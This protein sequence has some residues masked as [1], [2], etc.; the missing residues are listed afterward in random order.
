M[1]RFFC[2]II[3][4]MIQPKTNFIEKCLAFCGNIFPVKVDVPILHIAEGFSGSYRNTVW[5]IV[6]LE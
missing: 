2:R 1:G 3:F 4:K 6:H 5:L